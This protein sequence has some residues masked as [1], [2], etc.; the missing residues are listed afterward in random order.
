[1]R[2][3][4]LFAAFLQQTVKKLCQILLSAGANVTI[5]QLAVL[6]EKHRRDIHDAELF[7]G[8]GVVIHI[9]FAY[10]DAAV[11][12]VRELEEVAA[13]DVVRIFLPDLRRFPKS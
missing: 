2:F 3:F 5:D 8:V 9:Q 4:L 12:L 7:A 1:M 6:E 10:Y 11:V 13:R